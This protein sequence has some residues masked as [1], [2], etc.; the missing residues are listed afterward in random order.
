LT[1]FIHFTRQGPHVGPL[2]L[3]SLAP[4]P[5]PCVHNGVSETPT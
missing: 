3:A 2:Q 5:W 1:H 4:G